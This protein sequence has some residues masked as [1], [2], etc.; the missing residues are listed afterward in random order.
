L[1]QQKD[2]LEPAMKPTHLLACASLLAVAG[3]AKAAQASVPSDEALKSDLRNAICQQNWQQ[4]VTLSGRLA[5]SSTITP[6]YRQQMVNWRHRFSGYAA[7]G[8]RFD[9]IP[10]CDGVATVAP[11]ATA[12]KPNNA[13]PVAA[14]PTVN[15]LKADLKQAI[16]DQNW[17]GAAALSSRL[18]ASDMITSDY[19]Q[20]LV[21]WRH[22]FSEYA[23][24]RT[25]FSEIPNCGS[26]TTDPALSAP[27][28]SMADSLPLHSAQPAAVTTPATPTTPTQ[29]SASP[30]QVE[31]HSPIT[32]SDA[33]CF[34]TYADGRTVNLESMCR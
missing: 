3:Q 11:A 33:A 24:S 6:E 28:K 31:T 7:S 26:S 1:Y 14:A 13:T 21:Y 25:Y 16:C 17:Q 18:M 30:T 20:Q 29:V 9:S 5:A 32:T 10:N 2:D 34:V 4:A 22:Q 27:L 23:T 12:S 15:Q 19:R 8:M